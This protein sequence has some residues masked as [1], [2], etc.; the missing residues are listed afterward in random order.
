MSQ[1][2]D[3]TPKAAN[4]R[5]QPATSQKSETRAREPLLIR[6]QAGTASGGW[7]SRERTSHPLSRFTPHSPWHPLHYP[8]VPFH[9]GLGRVKGEL[10]K[11]II[12]TPEKLP[13]LM[14]TII[15]AQHQK[16]NNK[17]LATAEGVMI[18]WQKMVRC[19]RFGSQEGWGSQ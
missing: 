5:P 18:W 11:L 10:K 7:Q 13:S 8:L 14:I 2:Q 16:R 6:S 19:R 4:Q 17:S 3:R 15:K 1:A 12:L 9:R